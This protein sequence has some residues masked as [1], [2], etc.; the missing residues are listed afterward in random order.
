[1]K[2]PL[3]P[4]LLLSFVLG[5]PALAA[6]PAAAP[7]GQA[8]APSKE[9]ESALDRLKEGNRRFAESKMTALRRG[10]DQRAS[11]SKEQHPFAIIVGCSDSRVPP[12]IVFDQG[13]GDLFIVRVAGNVVDDPSL[14][15]I[16]YA[17]EHLGAKLILVLGHSRCGAVDAAVKGGNPGAHVAS[18]VEA[19]EPAVEVAKR[20]KGGNLLAEAVKANVQRVV[21][22]LKGSWPVLAPE[23]HENKLTV[24]G[25]VYDLETGL[26]EF[27]P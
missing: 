23:V 16:E 27:L 4:A 5:L 15:S 20:K 14:G 25:G 22:E 1:V 3:V 18:L 17:V 19:I 2:A 12:E 13:L 8:A 10:S 7:S 24:V 11:V 9:T 21:D 6:A 26:V